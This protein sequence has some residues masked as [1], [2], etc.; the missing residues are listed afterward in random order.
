MCKKSQKETDWKEL[1]HWSS[2]KMK[3]KYLKLVPAI[4]CQIFIFNQMIATLQVMK[5]VQKNCLISYILSHQ[6]WWCN[7]KQFLSYSKNS[8]ANLY[9]PS[10]YIRNYSTSICPSV[11]GNWGKKGSKLHKFEYLENEKSFLDEI[12]NTFHSFGRA[13]IWWKNK[14][15]K[16]NSGHKL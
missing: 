4:F 2:L 5:Q 8:S 12:K 9:K 10:Y 15:L 13:I 16:K 14:N 1:F 6:V 7:I 3:L 11:S